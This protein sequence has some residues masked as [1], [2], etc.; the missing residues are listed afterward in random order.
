MPVGL[1]ADRK[2]ESDWT[3]VGESSRITRIGNCSS[4]DALPFVIP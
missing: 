1:L 4:R 3:R 2:L